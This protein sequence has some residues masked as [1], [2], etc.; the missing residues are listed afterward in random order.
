MS[1]SMVAKPAMV[2]VLEA[3][4]NLLF[5]N[6]ELSFFQLEILNKVCVDIVWTISR[7][8]Y[9]ALFK[10]KERGEVGVK[11]IAVVGGGGVGGYFG[12]VLAKA[13][14]DVTFLARGSHPK[15]M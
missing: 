6:P 2:L 15:A 10:S 3:T 13:G 7:S 4:D 11:R 8:K 14:N 9:I 5:L 1:G 12:A